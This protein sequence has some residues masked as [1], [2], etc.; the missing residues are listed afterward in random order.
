MKQNPKI[1]YGHSKNLGNVPG[2]MVRWMKG[3][4]RTS[5]NPFLGK[6]CVEMHC[7]SSSSCVMRW[8]DAIHDCEETFRA[9]SVCHISGS[10]NVLLSSISGSAIVSFGLQV[11]MYTCNYQFSNLKH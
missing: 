7:N 5:L 1:C 4:K 8:Q 3:R 9:A 10:H 11:K 6:G 2:N